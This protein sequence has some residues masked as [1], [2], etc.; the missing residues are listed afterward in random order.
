ML[1]YKHMPPHGGGRGKIIVADHG[2]EKRIAEHRVGKSEVCPISV[3]PEWGRPLK[4]RRRGQRR[5]L[6][7]KKWCYNHN[8]NH[9]ETDYPLRA[10]KH[11]PINSAAK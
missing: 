3:I 11:I 7:V 2:D 9:L 1:R 6:S 10:G 5:R 4:L 8:T